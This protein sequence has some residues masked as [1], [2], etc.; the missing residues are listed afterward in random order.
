MRPTLWFA[1]TDGRGSSERGGSDF[2]HSRA[3]SSS[4]SE[5]PAKPYSNDRSSIPSVT[6]APPTVKTILVF[7]LLKTIS[8][9]RIREGICF[10][11]S[12][13][14]V[15]ILHMF[16]NLYASLK[17]HATQG[18]TTSSSMHFKMKELGPIGLP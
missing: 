15:I 9:A 12:V 7:F 2:I 10:T 3:G 8:R 4:R 16:T 14:L 6:V 18:K 5:A 1:G 13:K 17:R 11:Y